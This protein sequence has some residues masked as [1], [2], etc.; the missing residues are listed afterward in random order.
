MKMRWK[1]LIFGDWIAAARL[2]EYCK[3]VNTLDRIVAYFAALCIEAIALSH[4]GFCNILTVKC[5]LVSF[6]VFVLNLTSE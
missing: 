5:V 4:I 3:Y 2:Q 6:I 1:I